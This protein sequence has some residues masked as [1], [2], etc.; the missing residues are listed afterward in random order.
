[1]LYPVMTRLIGSAQLSPEVLGHIGAYLLSLSQAKFDS[2]ACW[3]PEQA[4]RHGLAAGEPVSLAIA[5]C[6]PLR[7]AFGPNQP[8]DRSGVLEQRDP[9]AEDWDRDP[10]RALAA[11]QAKLGA[12]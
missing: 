3:K 11:L 9:P 2:M 5:S 7:A 6:L 12:A 10:L 8:A 1:M 4:P